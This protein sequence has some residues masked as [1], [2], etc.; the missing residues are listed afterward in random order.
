V[1]QR[2]PDGFDQLSHVIS[3]DELAALA[4][5]YK[6]LAGFAVRELNERPSLADARY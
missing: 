5:R 4:E 3:D 2:A 6:Q 1:E